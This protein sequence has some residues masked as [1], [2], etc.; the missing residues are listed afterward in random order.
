MSAGC[1]CA[2]FCMFSSSCYHLFNSMSKNHYVALLRVD[3]IGI[4]LMIFGMAITLIY[5]GFHNYPGYGSSFLILMIILLTVNSILQCT[6][7]YMSEGFEVFRVLFYSSILVLLFG[8]AM[9]WVMFFATELEIKNFFTNLML[10]FMYIFL[11]FIFYVT[12]F[13]ERATNNYYI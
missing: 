10:S 2:I 9:T 5:T 3:L 12:K 8:V 6:P 4:S 11:G 13:P 7:C 1:F